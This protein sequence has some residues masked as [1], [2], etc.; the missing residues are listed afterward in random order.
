MILGPLTGSVESTESFERFLRVMAGEM[1]LRDLPPFSSAYGDGEL[2]PFPQKLRK[3][4]KQGVQ[5]QVT[6]RSDG[7]WEFAYPD[8]N[9]AGFGF[10]TVLDPKR[11][12]LFTLEERFAAEL[13]AAPANFRMLVRVASSQGVWYP[14]EVVWVNTLDGTTYRVLLS[15]VQVNPDF[16]GGS[17]QAVFPVGTVLDDAILRKTYTI[18]SGAQNDANAV[19]LFMQRHGLGQFG[20]SD[21]TGRFTLLRVALSVG[22]LLVFAGCAIWL[23]RR[24]KHKRVLL[25]FLAAIWGLRGVPAWAEDP[26]GSGAR[27]APPTG[28]AAMSCC[29]F[30]IA[31]LALE[32]LGRAYQPECCFRR[33]SRDGVK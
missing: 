10:R 15:D 24:R 19:R 8:P 13:P 3:W 9:L 21:A 25:L 16:A 5:V 6:Q 17:F 2:E 31:V 27:A 23:W 26:A 14:G 18:G 11:G 22:S 4:V 29:A 1:G 32:L 28:E 33:L 7:Q 20:P 12:G 30:K